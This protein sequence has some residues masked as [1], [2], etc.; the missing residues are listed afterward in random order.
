MS[1]KRLFRLALPVLC[2]LAGAVPGD[3]RAAADEAA[4]HRLILPV[5][6][7]GTL[8]ESVVHLNNPTDHPLKVDVAYRGMTGT[9]ITGSDIPCDV[10]SLGPRE[11]LSLP[12]SRL[13]PQLGSPDLEL[14]GYLKLLASGDA[15]PLITAAQTTRVRI[16]G[17]AGAAFRVEAEPMGSL[18]IAAPIV[19]GGLF[20]PNLRPLQVSG[21]SGEVVGSVPVDQ[22][23][24]CFLTAPDAGKNLLLSLSDASGT[25][26]FNPIPVKLVDGEM[27]RVD[28]FLA[29]GF[30]PGRHE[31]FTVT[32][33]TE[34]RWSPAAAASMWS[35]AAWAT[36]RR[37]LRCPRMQVAGGL[38]T[39]SR[40]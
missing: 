22:R 28:V 8:R 2:V 40:V 29:A 25:P 11:A 13:C 23:G 21:L 32:I 3:T 10:Q 39:R 34:M 36:G 4:S 17:A 1:C 5:V 38:C 6:V 31:D 26:V 9:P 33:S 15:W 18:D 27:R 35:R 14:I 7:L 16:A 19:I 37:A 20:A 30:G 24:V 12:L